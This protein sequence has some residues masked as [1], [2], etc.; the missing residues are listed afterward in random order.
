MSRFEEAVK[1]V[2]LLLD[3][4]GGETLARSWQV[5]SPK[6]RIVTTAAPEIA[7]Q[8]SEG[9]RGGWFRMRSDGAQLAEIAG[10]VAAGELTVVID[11]VVTTEQAGD[12]I[13]CNKQGHGA[14]KTV[15]RL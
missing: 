13:E 15:V 1:D 8:L 11:Q 14:G 4:V 6:G 9:R 10:K 7:A 2:D 12:A 3:L 5:L